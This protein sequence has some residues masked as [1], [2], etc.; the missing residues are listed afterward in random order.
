MTILE[1][2]IKVEYHLIDGKCD[3]WQVGFHQILYR[4]MKHANDFVE[5]WACRCKLDLSQVNKGSFFYL[6]FESVVYVR[7]RLEIYLK[8]QVLDLKL[9]RMKWNDPN[10]SQGPLHIGVKVYP[11]EEKPHGTVTDWQVLDLSLVDVEG[12][13]VNFFD[14]KVVT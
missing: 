3:L 2:L 13:D 1:L 8:R 10:Y 9:R 12:V 14:K 5:H 11:R 6:P 7:Y 4:S